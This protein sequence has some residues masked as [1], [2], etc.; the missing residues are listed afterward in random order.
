MC[1]IIKALTTQ[2]II[3]SIAHNLLLLWAVGGDHMIEIRTTINW[4]RTIKKMMSQ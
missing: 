2:F 3:N 4:L 1:V